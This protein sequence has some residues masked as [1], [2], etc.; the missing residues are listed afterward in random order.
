MGW[1]WDSQKLDATQ[2]RTMRKQNQTPCPCPCPCS[3]I[4]PTRC[5][6][7]PRPSPTVSAS[8]PSLPHFLTPAL[9]TPR[10][11]SPGNQRRESLPRPTSEVARQFDPPHRR[12]PARPPVDLDCSVARGVSQRGIYPGL[13]WEI[14]GNPCSRALRA[15]ISLQTG[16]V[17]ALHRRGTICGAVVGRVNRAVRGCGNGARDRREV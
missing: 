2:E 1:E 15:R 13:G 8:H 6:A 12:P 10:K 7:L 16:N 3:P 9:L 17:S 11:N 4:P 14:R 5:P